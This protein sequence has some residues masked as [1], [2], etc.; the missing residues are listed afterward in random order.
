[1]GLLHLKTPQLLTFN[2][3]FKKFK[4]KINIYILKKLTFFSFKKISATTG[5]VTKGHEW[6]PQHNKSQGRKPTP[7]KNT[8]LE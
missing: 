5:S 2:F 4:I 8:N 6:E 1:M 3:F 7:N